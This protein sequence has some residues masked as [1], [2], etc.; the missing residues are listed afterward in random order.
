MQKLNVS[1][2]T[3][4]GPLDLLLHLINKNKIDI[5]DIPIATITS[6]YMEY[7]EDTSF[8]MD[9]MS[10][11]IVMAST[12]LE[13]KARMLLPKIEQVKEEDSVDP[14][15]EL[16]EKL[17]EYK[18]YKHL[19]L[20]LNGRFDKNTDVF[21]GKSNIPQSLDKYIEKPDPLQLL[22]EVTLSDLQEVFNS[23]LLRYSDKKDEVR[24]NFN[25]V[26][27]DEVT[28]EDRKL[29]LEKLLEREE[30]ISFLKIFDKLS[31]KSNIIVTF[32]ALLELIKI[33]KIYV[34][35]EKLFGDI[36]IIKRLDRLND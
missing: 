24:H 33:D 9:G 5:Y 15:A 13:I 23:I 6:Q 14:R 28:V 31:S 20:E 8:D 1:L 35:Q 10:E 25:K 2:D 27:K 19:A 18:L 21:Y 16:V 36:L 7:I 32:L 22:D 12:L 30:K 26:K 34:V 29:F 17:L 11:F 3:F 4:A